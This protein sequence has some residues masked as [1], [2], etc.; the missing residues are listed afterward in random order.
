MSETLALLEA[1]GRAL[2]RQIAELG[3]FRPG[4]ITATGGRCGNPRCHCHRPGDAGHGPNLRLTYKR[5][6][7]TIT[8]TFP[9][10]AAQ[11]KTEREVAGFR[12][13]RQLSRAFVEVNA[14]ICR[15]RSVGEEQTEEE[16]KRPQP[17]SGRWRGK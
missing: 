17:S 12:K 6:G 5:G 4:S 2:L 1:E 15:Q 7:K 10:L 3:D 14:K 16:K 8:E 9:T 13:Y 11:R